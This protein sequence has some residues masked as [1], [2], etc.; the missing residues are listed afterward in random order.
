MPAAALYPVTYSH[1]FGIQTVLLPFCHKQLFILITT[2]P[3]WCPEDQPFPDLTGSSPKVVIQTMQ[4]TRQQRELL[5]S[6]I[7]Y[8]E[9]LLPKSGSDKN[10]WV[11]HK[12]CSF[13]P[14]RIQSRNGENNVV[15]TLFCQSK[16]KERTTRQKPH[17]TL[18]LEFT[19]ESYI[20]SVHRT[21]RRDW[22]LWTCGDCLNPSSTDRLPVI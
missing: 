11:A 21:L 7:C 3:P 19:I 18:R 22:L 4:F 14:S 8:A 9:Q 20:I 13:L 1:F 6:L 12:F 17:L 15:L 5:R 10:V 16:G 2:F